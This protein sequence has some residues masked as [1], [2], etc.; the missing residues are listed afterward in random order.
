M[1]NFINLP[2]LFSVDDLDQDGEVTID[3]NSLSTN[4]IEDLKGTFKVQA[5]VK[6][7]PDWWMAGHG[8]GDL[9]SNVKHIDFST[10]KRNVI[11]FKA[12]N[13]QPSPKF[14]STGNTQDHFFKSEKLSQ[15]HGREYNMRYS[16]FSALLEYIMK[17]P[18]TLNN[19][20][21]LKGDLSS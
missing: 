5:I 15:F 14:R 16:M 4:P 20:L 7:N 2:T 19:S 6:I 18:N 10:N 12:N 13:V 1:V 9:Y 21:D 3:R 8:I 11:T 17:L